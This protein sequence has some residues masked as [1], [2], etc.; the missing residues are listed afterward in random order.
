MEYHAHI[1][2]NV[3]LEKAEVR[4]VHLSCFSSWYDE[5]LERFNEKRFRSFSLLFVGGLSVSIFFSSFLCFFCL[6]ILLWMTFYIIRLIWQQ[7]EH[8]QKQNQLYQHHLVSWNVMGWKLKKDFIEFRFTD[9]Y[10]TTSNVNFSDTSSRIKNSDSIYH[11]IGSAWWIYVSNRTI[12][13]AW[14]WSNGFC[15]W[16]IYP[17]QLA[18]LGGLTAYSIAAQPQHGVRYITTTTP[19]GL[20]TAGQPTGAYTFG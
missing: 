15:F 14:Y 7:H 5:W 6:M 8:S 1:I 18:N 20:N 16:R 9:E 10:T 4:F 3:F 17:E 11:W 2:G 13:K 12:F 19:H